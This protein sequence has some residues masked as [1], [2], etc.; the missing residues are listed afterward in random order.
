[1]LKRIISGGQTGADIAGVDA[2]IECGLPYGGT[3]PKGRKCENG[4]IP[5][6]YTEF[7]ES[8]S[9]DYIPR[10]KLNIRNSGGTAIFCRNKPLT[11]G[12]R[13]TYEI[14][15]QYG[16]P[17][18]VFYMDEQLGFI[19]NEHYLATFISSKNITVLNV[20]GSRES[21]DPGIYEYTKDIVKKCILILQNS[22]K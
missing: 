14:A 8:I 11:S 22:R 5:L 7:V 1:M 21:K 13:M 4:V 20:A 16:R 19:G 2:A 10:T 18:I 6:T 3:V 12:S 17:C 9:S 15:T